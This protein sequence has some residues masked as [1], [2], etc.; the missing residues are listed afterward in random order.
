M[1][2]HKM[3]YVDTCI[4][5]N[6]FKMEGDPAKGVP[7]W[8][9]AKDFIDNVI[10][11]ENDEIAYSGLILKEIKFKLNND[12][13]FEEKLAFIRGEGKFKF[14]KVTDKDCSF[15]RKLESELEYSL[16]FFDCLHIALCKRLNLILVT[17]DNDLIRF[18][19][20]CISAD[21]PE[22]LS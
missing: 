6:L 19:Q 1:S 16:S 2:A 20:K 12:S 13:L 9:I 18:A 15:A 5:L 21:R 14:V 10:F 7:Y 4:W 8:K 17:R 11:S 22:N 3:F